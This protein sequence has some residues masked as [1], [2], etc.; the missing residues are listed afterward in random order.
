MLYSLGFEEKK[1]VN[2]GEKKSLKRF[3]SMYLAKTVV[4][5]R[6]QRRHREGESTTLKHLRIR[7]VPFT[8]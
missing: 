8:C 3:L 6:R 2:S 1:K 4:V 5:K 7:T